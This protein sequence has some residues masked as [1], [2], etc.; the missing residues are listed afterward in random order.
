MKK[1]T[2]KN[3]EK[4]SNIKNN[5]FKIELKD[6]LPASLDSNSIRPLNNKNSEQLIK[7]LITYTSPIITYLESML[8][9]RELLSKQGIKAEIENSELKKIVK[10]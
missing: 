10:K 5:I 7:Q 4:L 3:Q 2:I 6:K 1:E 8:K 9:K